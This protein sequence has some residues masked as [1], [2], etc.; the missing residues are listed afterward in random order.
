M[1]KNEIRKRDNKR[2][3]E[4]GWIVPVQKTESYMS[5]TKVK[6]IFRKW[7]KENMHC[8]KYTPYPKNSVCNEYHFRGISKRITLVM[9]YRIPEAMVYHCKNCCDHDV[10]QYI[11]YE[12]YDSK[13]G[14]YDSDRVDDDCELYPDGHDIFEYYPTQ[15]ELYITEVFEHIITYV[16]EKFVEGN[17]IYIN[18]SECY[19]SSTIAPKADYDKLKEN[20]NGGG[21][22][23]NLSCASSDSIKDEPVMQVYDLFEEVE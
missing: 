17:Q 8:F 20:F 18:K 22:C 9:D 23:L 13:R 3:Y 10:I 1:T 5:A 15:R 6:K 16:N 4:D 14:Y 21:F 12:K 2:R 11:G 7:L 19:S